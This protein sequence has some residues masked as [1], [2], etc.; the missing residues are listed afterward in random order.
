MRSS[1]AN[2][3]KARTGSADLSTVTA[4][5]SLMSRVFS[6]M[7]AST[8]AG[9]ETAKLLRLAEAPGGRLKMSD[10]A[11]AIVYSTGGLTRLFE[12]MRRG[13]GGGGGPAGAPPP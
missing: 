13:G 6:A 8:T 3:W 5:D 12:R 7:A 11:Q 1:V 2:C 10:L 9:A 4:L